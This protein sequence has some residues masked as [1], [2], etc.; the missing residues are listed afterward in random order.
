[1]EPEMPLTSGIVL[2]RVTQSTVAA[3]DSRLQ[4]NAA[5]VIFDDFIVAVDVGMRPYAS[6]L[7]REAL[8]S[9]FRR[10]VHFAC[11]TH[12]HA[13]HTFGLQAFKDVTLFGSR[14][15]ADALERSPDWT[16]EESAR[17]KLDDSEGGWLGEVELVLPSLRFDGRMDIANRGRLVEFHHAGGHT[18]C[19]VYGYL[20]DEKVLFASDLIFAGGFPFAGDATADPEVWMATLRAWTSMAIDHVIPGHGPVSGPGEIIRQLE[21][22]ETLKQNTLKAI[23][24]GQGGEDIEL[25]SVYPVGDKVWFAEKTAQRWH[26]YYSDYRPNNREV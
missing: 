2:Q 22:F 1:M 3:I 21:F 9:Q 10:P 8:E 12:C 16:P 17:R 14:R 26:A 23:E 7:F 6:R 15:L 25:P 24:A 19:L 18:D 20:P 4:S 11:I 5:A 13:D